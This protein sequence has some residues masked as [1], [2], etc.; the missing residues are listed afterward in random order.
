[1]LGVFGEVKRESRKGQA[2]AKEQKDKSKRKRTR[3]GEIEK[4]MRQ[5]PQHFGFLRG[6]P[7]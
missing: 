7:P 5:K 2:H 3:V 1:M 6:P 4:R